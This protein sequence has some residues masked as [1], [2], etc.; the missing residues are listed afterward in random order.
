MTGVQT[1]ALPIC[2]LREI[3]SLS[4]EKIS[5]EVAI[6]ATSAARDKMGAADMNRHTRNHWGIENKGHYVRD[7]AFQEDRNQSWAGNGPQ[8]IASLHNFAN[9][10]FRM[11]GVKSIKEAAEL[12]HMDRTLA[13]EYLATGHDDRYAALPPNSPA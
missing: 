6:Q 7:T 13:L 9:S 4:G 10:L 1:C 3:F 5:K 2:I 11:K 8:A 12:I